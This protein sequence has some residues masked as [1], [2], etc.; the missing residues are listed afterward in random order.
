[1]LRQLLRVSR[2]GRRLRLRFAGGGRTERMQRC[3][4]SPRT[5]GPPNPGSRRRRRLRSPRTPT[6][7]CTRPNRRRAQARAVGVPHPHVVRR[8]PLHRHH[9]RLDARRVALAREARRRPR[10][11]PSRPRATGAG[12]V[13]GA[14]RPRSAPRR[15]R[16]RTDPRRERA[17]PRDGR[18]F[19]TVHPKSTTRPTALQ[20]WSEDW[21]RMIDARGALRRRAGEVGDHRTRKVRFIY[22]AVNA[23]TPVTQPDGRLRARE[24]AAARTRASPPRCSS[25]SSKDQREYKKVTT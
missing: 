21:G 16:G 8:A 19:A 25:R 17:A 10:P 7:R 6:A 23:I 9:P 5:A 20:R 1:M 18:E 4:T 24:H 3:A 13:E 22:P 2:H 11:P 12:E 14:P 15:R